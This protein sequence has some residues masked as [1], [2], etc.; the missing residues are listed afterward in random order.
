MTPDLTYLALSAVLCLFL[1]WPHVNARALIIGPAK[2]AGYPDQEPD[3]PKWISR[4]ARAHANMIENLPA[5][6]ALVLVAHVGGVA[7]DMTALGA[8][9]FFW[10]KLAHA[11]IHILGIPYARTAAFFVAWLGMITIAWQILI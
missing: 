2:A 7:N 3:M 10:G 6:A 11:I 4:G 1:W 5:F 9:I 8:A